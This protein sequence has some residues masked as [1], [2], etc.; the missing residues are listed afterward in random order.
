MAR[1]RALL[2]A[3]NAKNSANKEAWYRYF[4]NAGTFR[5]HRFLRAGAP[6][7]KLGETK[8][9]RAQIK[10]A[11]QIKPNAHF[12]REKYQLMA[13]D[14][15]IARKSKRTKDTLGQW[16]ARGDKWKPIG[17]DTTLANSGRKRAVE[18]L[19]GLIVL[20]GAWESPDVFEALGAALETRDSVTLRYIAFLRAQELLDKNKPSWAE[21]KQISEALNPNGSAL[22]DYRYAVNAINASNLEELFFR[23]RTEAEGWNALRQEW[24]TAK[25]KRGLHPDTNSN[26]WESYG[27]SE[28]PSLDIQWYNWSEEVGQSNRQSI[29]VVCLGGALLCASILLLKRAKR[30]R[31]AL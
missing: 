31:L 20:G 18:G 19:S 16:I 29:A 12:G 24:M 23:C 21:S 6:S 30:R 28:P 25:L 13:M 3:F 27:E 10:R 14:W 4:A 22:F 17:R 2:P 1:K 9:A 15:I 11:L 8:T 26:F 5:A 7:Q